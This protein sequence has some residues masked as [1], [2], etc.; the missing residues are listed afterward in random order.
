MKKITTPLHVKVVSEYAYESH[1]MTDRKYEK[2]NHTTAVCIVF[3]R[4]AEGFDE[5]WKDF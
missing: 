3:V 2:H 4:E 1:I 5:G